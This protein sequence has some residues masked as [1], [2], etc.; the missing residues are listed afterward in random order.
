ML[1]MPITL[2][3]R[4]AQMFQVMIGRDA[5]SAYAAP[6]QAAEWSRQ[7]QEAGGA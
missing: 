2:V 5:I 7:D 1:M 6:I 4:F 3:L